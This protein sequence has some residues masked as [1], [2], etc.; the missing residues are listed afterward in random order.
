MILVKTSL[1]QE[2]MKTFEKK[3]RVQEGNIH[4]FCRG[5]NRSTVF[6]NDIER[7]D[8]IRRLNR[9]ANFYDSKIQEFALMDNHF[10]LQIRTEQLSIFMKSLLQGY[11]KFASR[12]CQMV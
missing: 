10:H 9:I 1:N 2:T 7:Y 5:N 8:F 3:K 11:E 4:V 6:Y 12:L